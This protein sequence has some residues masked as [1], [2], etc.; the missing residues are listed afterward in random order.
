[1]TMKTAKSY[2]LGLAA[3]MTLTAGFSACQDDFDA[4]GI[5][6]PVAT[7]EANTTIAEL[8]ATFW[9]DATNYADTVR[10]K[11]NG[12]HYIIKGRVTSSDEDGNVFKFITIQD[13]T[14][15]MSFSVN[16][17]NLYLS[18]RRGQE[19]VVD[20]TGMYIGKYAGLQQ[21]GTPSYYEN[22]STWQVGFMSPELFRGHI[23][24]NGIPEIEKLDTITVNSFSE[25]DTS[26]EG[27]RKWQSQLVRINNVHFQDGGLKTFSEYHS[28]ANDDVNKTLVDAEGNSNVIVRTSGYA[29]FWNKTLPEGNGDIVGILS[30]Y[31][32]LSGASNW[33]LILLD[34]EGCMNFGN[35]TVAPG[36][37]NNPYSVADVVKLESDGTTAKGWVSGYIV[38]SVAPGVKDITS[39]DDITWSSETQ[40]P[41]TLVIGADKETKDINNAL[42]IELPADS[43]LRQHGN[44]RDNPSNYGK[45]ISV[46]GTFSKVM[47]TYGVAGNSGASSQFKIEGVE[48]GGG[49]VPEGDGTAEKPYNATQAKTKAI[50]NGSSSTENVYVKGYIISGAINMTYGTGTWTICDN[51]QGTGETFELFGTYN[52]DNKKFTD[53]NAVKVGDLIVAVGPIYNYNNKTPEMSKGHLVSINDDGGTTPDPTPGEG[54]VIFSESFEN[55]NLGQ[56]TTS[57]ETSSEWTGWRANTKSPLC[58]IANSYVGG[59]NQAGTAWLISPVIDLSSATSAA[60]TFEH[61]FGFY[62]PTAQE[63]FCT[64]NVREQGGQ[65]QQ[66]TMTVYPTKGT[67]NWTSFATNTLDLK[68]FTGKKIEIGFK[69]INDGAQS[70]AWEIKNF[71][72]E[73]DAGSVTPGGGG[74]VTPDPT[75]DPDASGTGTEADPYNCAKVISINPTSKTE[76]SETDVWIK[77][78]IIGYMPANNTKPSAT[79]TTAEGCN[80]KTNLV[81]APT[82]TEKDFTK[83]L[84]VQL[85][86]DSK[87][88]GIRTALNLQ[89]HPE[90]LGKEVLLKGDIILYCGAPGIKET[91]AY[92][93]VE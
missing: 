21:F 28:N 72:V 49:S 42:V 69:Y 15:S 61:A 68:A 9:Q 62:F 55:G 65:W 27:L 24:L 64:V 77:G 36:T 13:E 5:E 74:T 6:I 81:L 12:D 40:M 19:I 79:I 33:Q 46:Y 70:I 91:S 3:A 4:P 78:Y 58:A 10:T 2:I 85:P 88:P 47:G 67:G 11:E 90:N 93:F 52:T 35:P 53:E 31:Q 43:P 44:L 41:Y 60:V 26:A 29:N 84:P 51:A 76:A 14:G 82:P 17:Y 56:F 39:N 92:K 23:E 1:M 25:F 54:N 32:N 8:K 20:A 37:E 45:A 89:D 75:P 57:V 83:C 7:K 16:S 30:F 34:Y 66:L 63:K 87:A 86:T 48:T 80:V 50:A 71:S 38:G 18:Y 59:T 22:G 73:A